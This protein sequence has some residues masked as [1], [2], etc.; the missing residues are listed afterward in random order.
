MSEQKVKKI[1]AIS[2]SPSKGRN[3]DTMLDHFIKGV[4]SKNDNEIEV[5]KIYLN[6]IE[7][8]YY[9]YENKNGPLENEKDFADLANKIKNADGIIIATPTYN[10]SVPAKLKNLIDRIRFIA[11]DLERKNI[12][13]QPVGLL[14]EKKFFFIVSGGTS[15]IIQKIIFFLYP[16]FWLKAV[17]AYYGSFKLKSFYSGD[18]KSFENQKIL[19]KCFKKGRKFARKII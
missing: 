2:A 16:A 14:K 9:Q 3:S 10:F 1:I 11:L 5:E 6:D 13:G 4:K 7:F 15:N 17:F 19:K 18:L 8:D 12:L